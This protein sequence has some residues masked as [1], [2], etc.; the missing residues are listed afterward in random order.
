MTNEQLNEL[1]NIRNSV[2]KFSAKGAGCKV[3]GKFIR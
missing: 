3:T 2:N 1:Q